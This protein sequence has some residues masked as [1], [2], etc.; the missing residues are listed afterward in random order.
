MKLYI[1]AFATFVAA[2]G[3][4]SATSNIDYIECNSNKR[5]AFS[6]EEFSRYCGNQNRNVDPQNDNGRQYNG[7]SPSYGSNN[8]Y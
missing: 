2:A 6:D 7:G 8:S 3:S 1:L 4:A 5:N